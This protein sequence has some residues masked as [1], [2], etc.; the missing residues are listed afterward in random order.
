MTEGDINWTIC[1]QNIDVKREIIEKKSVIVRRDK[2]L[3]KNANTTQYNK[4]LKIMSISTGKET[5]Y[6]DIEKNT[7]L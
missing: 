5:L 3:L 2:M 4:N 1:E 7:V 6:V